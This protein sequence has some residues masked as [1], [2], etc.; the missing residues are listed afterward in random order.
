METSFLKVMIAGDLTWCVKVIVHGQY[1]L[2]D[3]RRGRYNIH[4]MMRIMH[5]FPLIY[6]LRL[7]ISTGSLRLE[8]KKKTVRRARFF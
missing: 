2:C 3:M 7:L 8:T 5:M 4:G 1:H 6:Y